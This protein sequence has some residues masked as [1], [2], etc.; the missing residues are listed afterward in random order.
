MPFITV[1]LLRK[2]AEHNEGCLRDLKEITLHQ[3]DLE[4]I[5]VIN[6]ECK[7]LEILYLQ[8]NLISRIENLF[9][10]KH[11]W[12]LNLAINNIRSIENLEPL[13]SLKKLD[14]TL[15]FIGELTSI[16]KLQA[17]SNLRQLHLTGNNCTKIPGYRYY[18]ID[19]LPQLEQL[20]SEDI[21]KSERI[22]GRQEAIPVRREVEQ[23]VREVV[24]EEE[25]KRRERELGI[26]RPRPVDD[27]GEKLYSHTP[28]DRMA[29]YRDMQEEI[30]KG[31]CKEK[32]RFDEIR[33]EMKVK[34]LTPEEEMAKYGR[35][36]QRNQAGLQ[37]EMNEVGAA[38]ELLVNVPKFISTALIDCD[39]QPTYIRIT[40]KSKVLQLTLTKEVAPDK[41][42]V[43]RGQVDGRLKVVMP[44]A[45]PNLTA[46][47]PRWSAPK[48]N[49]SNA[50]PQP[51]KPG[52]P[53]HPTKGFAN[54]VW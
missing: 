15:N 43:T 4:R 3:Q 20:D 12:Y 44:F 16:Q 1:E 19:T 26:E 35:Y 32:S 31:K 13:E 6:D 9:H 46:P 47:P 25:R 33:D 53:A 41:V 11:L 17:N 21:T 36:L 22:R 8:N 52:G 14:L 7:E 18:V 30:E 40:I 51:S 28:E 48:S 54:S 29:A 5:D 10:L 24:E 23:Q 50:N 42:V 45:D 27:K 34:P 49:A 37:Y 39:V 38:V 2:R